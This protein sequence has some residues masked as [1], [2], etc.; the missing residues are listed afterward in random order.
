[1]PKIL[2][3]TV[4]LIANQSDDFSW[5]KNHLHFFLVSTYRSAVRIA[6]LPF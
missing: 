6:F 2:L 4:N 3:I 1:M 5:K